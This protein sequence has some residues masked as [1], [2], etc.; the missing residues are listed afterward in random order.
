LGISVSIAR[1]ALAGT[2]YH[3]HTWNARFAADSFS[4]ALFVQAIEQQMRCMFIDTLFK[5]DAFFADT[6]SNVSAFSFAFS[7]S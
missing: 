5:I 2:H 6:C 7:I 1:P 4:V 3:Y